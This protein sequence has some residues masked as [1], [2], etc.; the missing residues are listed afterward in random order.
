MK[1]LAESVKG[2]G[3]LGQEEKAKGISKK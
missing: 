1:Y 3:R 2:T